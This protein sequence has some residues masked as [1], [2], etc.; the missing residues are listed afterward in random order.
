MVKIDEFVEEDGFLN[1]L[2]VVWS[3]LT[4][5]FLTVFFAALFVGIWAAYYAPKRHNLKGKHVMVIKLMNSLL[6]DN[7]LSI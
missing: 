2:H 5:E 3:L 1:M 6:R 7:Q 4:V